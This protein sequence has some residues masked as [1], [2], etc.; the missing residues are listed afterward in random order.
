MY[1]YGLLCIFIVLMYIYGYLETERERYREKYYNIISISEFVLFNNFVMQL[2]H[3][4][5][6]F[7]QLKS[8]NIYL[9]N[10]VERE[11][12]EEELEKSKKH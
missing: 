8:T 2:L 7:L 3:T 9:K 11:R 6:R 10:W 12:K 1:I 5:S 4:A